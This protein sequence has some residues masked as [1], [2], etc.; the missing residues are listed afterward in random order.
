MNSALAIFLIVC[1]YR[2]NWE[3]FSAKLY[4]AVIVS[5]KTNDIINFMYRWYPPGHGDFYTSF[6]NS[7]LLDKFITDV[8]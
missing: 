7:G 8:S 2:S 1:Q 4:V 3:I 6:N 5:Q